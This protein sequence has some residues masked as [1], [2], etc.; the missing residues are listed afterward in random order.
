V[1]VDDSTKLGAFY[2]IFQCKD[3]VEFF[4]CTW[5]IC[6]TQFL[7][8]ITQVYKQ[9]LRLHKTPILFASHLHLCRNMQIVIRNLYVKYTL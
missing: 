2:V 4:Y 3:L 6:C 7:F 5:T 1:V 8:Y 9:G